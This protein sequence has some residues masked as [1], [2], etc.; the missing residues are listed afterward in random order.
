LSLNEILKDVSNYMYK[1]FEN[2]FIQNEPGSGYCE[3]SFDKA[4][5]EFNQ[6]AEDHKGFFIN[7]E[8]VS[9]SKFIS[10]AQNNK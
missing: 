6:F 7:C 10:Y 8:K 3:Y 5:L 2:S 4:R 1:N 9:L